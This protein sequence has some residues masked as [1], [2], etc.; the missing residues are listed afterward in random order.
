MGGWRCRVLPSVT[1]L[2]W[3]S[4]WC[5]RWS[6]GSAPVPSFRFSLPHV[7]TLI[8]DLEQ[9]AGEWVGC[10]PIRSGSCCLAVGSEEAVG[11]AASRRRKSHRPSAR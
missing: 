9:I 4:R 6:D 11:R 10:R 7:D 2:G 5:V 3:G 8:S 1:L